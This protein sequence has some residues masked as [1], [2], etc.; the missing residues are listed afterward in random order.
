MRTLRIPHI[1]RKTDKLRAGPPM[2]P[3]ARGNALFK[4]NHSC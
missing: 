1:V 3:A 4:L 2:V